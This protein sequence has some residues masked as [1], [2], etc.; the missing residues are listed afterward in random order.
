MSGYID[1]NGQPFEIYEDMLGRV[2][3]QIEEHRRVVT[4]LEGLREKPPVR[5]VRER[6]YATLDELEAEHA[7]WWAT[8]E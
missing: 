8:K 4:S 6:H 7:A 2:V 3:I 1:E 5:V